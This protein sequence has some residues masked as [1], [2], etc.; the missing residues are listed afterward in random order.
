MMCFSDDLFSCHE[1]RPMSHSMSF[2]CIN[3]VPTKTL[4]AFVA[5][6]GSLRIGYAFR[7]HSSLIVYYDNSNSPDENTRPL[8]KA[9]PP[10][11][12]VFL[13]FQEMTTNKTESQL[14]NKDVGFE[15]LTPMVLEKIHYK[16]QSQRSL[17]GETFDHVVDSIHDLSVEQLSKVL[18]YVSKGLPDLDVAIVVREHEECITDERTL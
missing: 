3:D 13:V 18:A 2:S 1:L 10:V 12:A 14:T 16:L 8:K 9:F 7:T 5:S 17:W 11:C 6:G 4:V 15:W